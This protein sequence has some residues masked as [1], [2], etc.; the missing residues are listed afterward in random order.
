M[1][2]EAPA[3]VRR[4]RARDPC[5]WRPC[6]RFGLRRGAFFFLPAYSILLNEYFIVVL[7]CR[8][9]FVSIWI[10]ITGPKESDAGEEAAPRHS[11]SRNCLSDSERYAGQPTADGFEGH[12]AAGGSD[13]KR[14][15]QLSGQ[16][17]ANRTCRRGRETGPLSPG[18][19]GAF[20]RRQRN[21][22]DRRF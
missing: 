3:P 5:R 13:D 16:P 17:G 7:C 4:R 8:H 15:E 12:R 9:S 22:A 18:A 2:A 20:A 21:T 1:P 10:S 6:R 19:F 11:V 14:C